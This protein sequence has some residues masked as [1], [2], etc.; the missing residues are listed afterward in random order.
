VKL[1]PISLR[2]VGKATGPP[3]RLL[4][5]TTP[6]YLPGA[7]AQSRAGEQA[8]LAGC[9]GTAPRAGDLGQHRANRE[10]HLQAQI[11]TET[12]VKLS[13]AQFLQPKSAENR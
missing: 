11:F 1:K 12:K 7:F 5:E 6:P 10:C 2:G 13:N 3:H 8:V 4:C 9:A